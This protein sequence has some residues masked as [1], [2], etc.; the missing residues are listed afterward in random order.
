MPFSIM[1]SSF[2][3]DYGVVSILLSLIAAYGI[4]SAFYFSYLHP[5]SR[6]PG[7][8]LAAVSNLWYAYHWLSGRYPWA[9]EDALRTYGPVV[10]IAP[11]ELVFF[12][13]AAFTDI[14]APHH[15]NLE[16]FVKTDFQD[17]GQDLGGIIWERDPHRHREVARKLSS[18][19]SSRTVRKMEPLVHKY[20]DYF[21]ARMKEL[22][23]DGVPIARW[24]N[25]LAMDLS[26]D[27]AWNEKMYQMRD[28]KDSIH[29]DV[30][31]SF[32]KFA[33][34][35]QVFKR[36]PL[37]RPFQYLFVPITKVRVFSAMEAV[38][39][40]SIL[41]RI[42]QRGKTEHEDYFDY[43]LPPDSPVPTDT[44]EL[45]HIASVSLQT[46]FAAWGPM[47]DLFYG[48]LVLLLHEPSSYEVLVQEIRGQFKAYD[49]ITPT[50]VNSLAYLQACL[51][52]TLRLLP[53]NDTGLPRTSPGATVDGQYI[54]KGT[55]V[56]TSIWALARSP[57]FFHQPLH[58]RPQRWLPASH[59]L[60][61]PA[62]R[63]DHL[64][65]LYPFSLGPRICLGREMAW[66]QGRLFLAKVLW[67]F[68]I[69]KLDDQYF[70]LEKDLLHYGFF[71][72]PE[73]MV[74]F[75]PA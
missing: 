60:Y 66:M 22:G 49:A 27:M 42:D 57:R 3:A 39:R 65:S 6:Y 18:A 43:I 31:I 46:M 45:V 15:K 33:T 54:P 30:L 75:V 59:P 1:S 70:E 21:V 8:R 48:A 72:K 56:Q 16:T 7:P 11:N 25:W 19:F 14:Y 12:T 28:M 38:T 9:I 29:L 34:V 61:D 52:E 17:R 55:T 41:R 37:L 62:F 58:F 50:A 71:E 67:T 64:S 26:A 74:R 68:N 5:L 24:T 2:W 47:A 4:S 51:E 63:E 35:M 13:P 40:E 73:L 53:S 10:R 20:I 23:S 36:F 44:R 69:E 32:N